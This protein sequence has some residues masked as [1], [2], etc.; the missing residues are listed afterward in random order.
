MVSDFIT[1]LVIVVK[2]ISQ[3][4]YKPIG[5]KAAAQIVVG[6]EGMIGLLG[7]GLKTRLLANGMQGLMFSALLTSIK[8]D[9]VDQIRQENTTFIKY[10]TTYVSSMG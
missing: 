8:K 6:K 2:S 9:V 5:Y 7:R 3:T 10:R 1:K 4:Y